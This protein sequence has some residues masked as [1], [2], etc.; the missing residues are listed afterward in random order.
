[1]QRIN[2]TKKKGFV[3]INNLPLQLTDTLLISLNLY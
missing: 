1:M 3:I 2:V